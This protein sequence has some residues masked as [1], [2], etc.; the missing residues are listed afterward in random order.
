[1]N[2]QDC[3]RSSAVMSGGSSSA[4]HCGRVSSASTIRVRLS[5]DRRGATDPLQL[6]HLFKCARFVEQ[7]SLQCE[8]Q[9][10]SSPP[11]TAPPDS[12]ASDP[13]PVVENRR[14]QIVDARLAARGE[15]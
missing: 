12:G 5:A 3:P 15:R 14:K 9:G 7:R 11:A 2:K 8:S 6:A 4:D 13:T 10:A 1:M